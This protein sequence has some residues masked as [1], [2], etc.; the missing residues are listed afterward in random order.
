MQ[1]QGKRNH[2]KER[3]PFSTGRSAQC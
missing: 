2:Q 1:P 3:A